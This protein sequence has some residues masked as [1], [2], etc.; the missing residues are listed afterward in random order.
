MTSCSRTQ[1]INNAA[2]SEAGMSIGGKYS[3]VS[4][5]LLH[6]V[7]LVL[8]VCILRLSWYLQLCMFAQHSVHMQDHVL[9]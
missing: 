9:F 4:C 2:N 6:S 8:G 1:N 7:C 5:T 3:S